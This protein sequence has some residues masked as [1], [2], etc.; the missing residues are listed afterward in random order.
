MAGKSLPYVNKIDQAFWDGT[1]MGKLLLQQCRSC[2]KLQFFPR[3]V[4]TACF[5]SDLAWI[6]ASGKGKVHSFT[7]VR[8]PRNQAFGDEVPICY[9]DIV[10]DEGVIMQSR[11]VGARAAKVNMGENVM[12]RF[13]ETANPEIKLPVFEIVD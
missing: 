1:K 6:P 11:L 12:V 4:C 9:A 8:V 5:G 10:L 3:A 2:G 7:W 13:Q